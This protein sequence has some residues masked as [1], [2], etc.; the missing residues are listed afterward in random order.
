MKTAVKYGRAME[1]AE[2]Y[3][4]A[5]EDMDNIKIGELAE[6]KAELA[7]EILKLEYLAI[8]FAPCRICKHWD[9]PEVGPPC[10]D[11]EETPQGWS[12]FEPKP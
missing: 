1:L 5:Y 10:C 2:K 9:A 7:S 12:M 3:A 11:C 4:I 6:I 8:K